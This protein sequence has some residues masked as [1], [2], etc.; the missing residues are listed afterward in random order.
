MPARV[1]RT[2]RSFAVVFAAFLSL[3]PALVAVDRSVVRA[4]KRSGASDEDIN[5][6][7]QADKQRLQKYERIFPPGSWE[8]DQPIMLESDGVELLMKDYEN[9][10]DGKIRLSQCT[11][12]YLSESPAGD[13]APGRVVVLRARG[14]PPTVRLRAEPQ[15]R[16]ARQADRRRAQRPGDDSRHAQPARRGRRVVHH[17]ARHPHGR[18]KDLVTRPRGVSLWPKRGTRARPCDPSVARQQL[19]IGSRAEYRWFAAV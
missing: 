12:L 9:L 1:R 10:P 15:A 2:V 13:A 18:A 5:R 11:M 4:Q 8:L 7:H 6:F 17:H 14:G 3:P 16:Q 19:A